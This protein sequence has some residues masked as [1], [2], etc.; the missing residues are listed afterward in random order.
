MQRD[1]IITWH[2]IPPSPAVEEI[3]KTRIAAIGRLAPEA[4]G[5]RV[6]LEPA[7]HR[8]RT[9][10]GFDV[11]IHLE[12]PGPDVDV[13]KAI[14]QGHAAD[15]LVLAVNAAFGALERRLKD[16][17]Q[18]MRGRHVK[19]HPPVLHGEIV[20]FEPELGWGMLRA[21]DG[22]EVYFQKDSLVA[23]DW[24]ALD[25]GTRLK[26]REIEGEKGPFAADVSPS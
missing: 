6:T 21:D 10:Q 22:R 26:F 24:T 3:V 15:D 17:R 1:P 9:A 5:C 8:K 11:R 2:Q 20:D 14:R 23:G 7:E 19:Q 13:S 18:Q 16:A 25:R 4:V 12:M